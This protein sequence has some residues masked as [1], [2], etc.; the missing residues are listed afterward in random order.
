MKTSDTSSLSPEAVRLP[1]EW[2]RHECV[3]LAWPHED[4]DWAYM[5]DEARACIADIVRAVS[6]RECVLPVGRE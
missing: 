6:E 2:E 3:L 1:A 4:T 5:L